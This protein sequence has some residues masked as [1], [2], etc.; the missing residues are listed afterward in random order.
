MHS[1]HK[2]PADAVEA[3]RPA[4][5]HIDP[6]GPLIRAQAPASGVYLPRHIGVGSDLVH[7]LDYVVYLQLQ[8]N[9]ASGLPSTAAVVLQQFR[10]RGIRSE[11]DDRELVH[12]TEIRE[13]VARVTALEVTW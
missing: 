7:A 10:E 1:Q 4:A 13:S 12:K 11:A 9:Q 8:F 6:S 5:P 3:P 2:P